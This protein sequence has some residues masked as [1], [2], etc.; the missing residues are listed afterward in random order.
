MRRVHNAAK[1]IFTTIFGAPSYNYTVTVWLPAVVKGG[2]E[3]WE[4]G[5]CNVQGAAGV[6]RRQKSRD[7]IDNCDVT[8]SGGLS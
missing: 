5:I 2:R 4:G 7:L 1:K 8:Y 3:V 6:F